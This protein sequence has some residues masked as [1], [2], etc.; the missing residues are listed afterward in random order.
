MSNLYTF[1]AGFDP[2]TDDDEPMT[3][4]DANDAARD[5][6]QS[7]IF[8]HRATDEEGDVTLDLEL[9]QRRDF[10]ATV[11]AIADARRIQREIDQAW[12]EHEANP[13][14]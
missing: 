10:D 4:G 9:E 6:A 8:R 2:Y 12:R 3:Y 7:E 11:A 1:L 5:A 13:D 14:A